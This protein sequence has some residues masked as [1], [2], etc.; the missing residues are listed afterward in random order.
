MEDAMKM[1]IPTTVDAVK[2][3]LELTAQKVKRPVK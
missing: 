2:V 3:T 1:V